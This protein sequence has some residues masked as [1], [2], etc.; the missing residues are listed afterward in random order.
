MWRNALNR[1]QYKVLFL[2][3]CEMKRA[4]ASVDNVFFVILIS[5]YQ[6]V[7]FTTFLGEVNEKS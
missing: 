3:L 6:R 1:R 7:V 2:Y 4:L 5:L